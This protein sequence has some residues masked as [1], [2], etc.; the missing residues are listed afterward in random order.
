[1]HES[2]WMLI[3][4]IA[5][6]AGCSSSE[7]AAAPVPAAKPAPA[8]EPVPAEAEPS[9][10]TA[11]FAGYP[12]RCEGEWVDLAERILPIAEGFQEQNIMYDT[13]ELSDCSGMFH[14]L[15]RAFDEGC[16]GHS[17][18]QPESDRDS[19]DVARW[20]EAKGLFTQVRD[21]MGHVDRIKPGAVMF[22]GHSN[23]SY[24]EADLELV[25]TEVEHV[26]TVVSVERDGNGDL[27]RYSIFHGR[28][29]GK[30][31]GITNYHGREPARP[32]HRPFGNWD[33]QWIGVAPLA[34]ASLR[35]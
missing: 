23:K 24:E 9:P 19:R 3:L 2:S 4:S 6:A 21:E 10:E 18:P 5:L 34:D 29:P 7:P 33:Q 12:V 17:L 13:I 26:G 35:M 20:Y 25:L 15:L 14:R 22:Y 28:S 16:P 27:M 1:M 30:P 32:G 31:A 11:S 8:E